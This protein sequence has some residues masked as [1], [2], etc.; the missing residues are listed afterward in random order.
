MALGE[1]GVRETCA[2]APVADETIDATV[3]H[4]SVV[5]AD[6]VRIMRLTGMRAGELCQLAD[7]YIDRKAA[8]WLFS[9]PRHK[10]RRHGKSRIIAIGPKAQSILTKYLFRDPCFQ[11]T[12]ASFRRAIRRGCDRAFPHPTIKPSKTLPSGERR[13]LCAMARTSLGAESNSAHGSNGDP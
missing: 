12:T 7:K 9:P 4:L 10:T 8:V 13:E 2:V 11:Y 5:V 1:Y 3:A 6:M